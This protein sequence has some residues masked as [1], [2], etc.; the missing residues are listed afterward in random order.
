MSATDLRPRRPR[1][2]WRRLRWVLLAVL[3]V[4]TLGATWV[5][6]RGWLAKGHL[7]ASVGLAQEV[8]GQ[9]G[10]GDLAAVPSTVARLQGE[11][12]SAQRLTSD[13]VWRAAEVLPFAGPNLS[14]VRAVSGV[15][16][17]VVDDAVVPVAD[18]AASVDLE[19]FNPDG[20]VVDLAPL[21]EAQPAVAR[22]ARTI[23]E[24]RR[25]AE[26]IDSSGALAPVVGAVDQLRD[27][28][29]TVDVQ[30]DAAARTLD[31][32]PTLLGGDG[33][34]DVLVLFQ[35]NAELRA[36]GGIPGAAA[37]VR[38]D[39]GRIEL[40]QQAS[41]SDFDTLPASILPLP[42]D[43]AGLYGDITGRYI[44]DVNL[45]PR[46]PL[47]AELASAMWERQFGTPVDA[48][49]SLDPVAL[50]YLLEA[51]GPVSLPTGDV[52]TSENVVATLLSDV[53]ARYPDPA[54]QDD[55]FAGAAATVFSTVAGG[56]LDPAALIAA[57][58]RAGDER[59]LYLWSADPAQQARLEETTLAGTLPVS[60]MEQPRFGVYVN[61]GTG[62]KM[63]YYLRGEV[64][65][66][67]VVCRA[68]GRATHIV[69]V[70][71]TNTAP[72]SAGTSLPDY[73]TGAGNFGVPPGQ[74]SSNVSVY[75]PSSGLF[76][77]LATE[78]D[79]TAQTTT[80]SGHPVVQ[81]QTTLSPGESSTWKFEFL[82]GAAGEGDPV[83]QV[84]PFVNEVVTTD[85]S[86]SCDSPLS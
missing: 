52:L 60:T 25:V 84:T 30:A 78:S 36:T 31:L 7:E 62:A 18:V 67:K 76:V 70:K 71:L 72:T 50:S 63:S 77:G 56:D 4:V 45:T 44:Q 51:T 53:Y 13:P 16:D 3:L 47:S 59:R 68:D 61:D 86:L 9:L 15:L 42:V 64:G 12:S 49:V 32:A 35:N 39:A 8:Q 20:G 80:D 46:F 27:V 54:V 75:A 37:L 29:G 26:E 73:V 17:T 14:S 38:T 58:S 22:A 2:R 34:R 24:Q 79:P 55:F 82:G 40:V 11:A 43:T 28:L 6:V 85:L 21:V 66:G 65:V 5:G 41:S 1:S 48:V 69:S 23:A 81:Y 74:I 10:G 57:L 33:P 83:A 19:A